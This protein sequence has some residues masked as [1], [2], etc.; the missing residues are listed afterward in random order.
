MGKK[1]KYPLDREKTSEAF[2]NGLVSVSIYTTDPGINILIKGDH[3]E[4][5]TSDLQNAVDEVLKLHGK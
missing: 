5:L 4:A 3:S 1:N 2:T